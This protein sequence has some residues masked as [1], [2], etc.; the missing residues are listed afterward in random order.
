LSN[1]LAALWPDDPHDGVWWTGNNDKTPAVA[2]GEGTPP[3]IAKVVL[4]DLVDFEQAVDLERVL[5][6]GSEVYGRTGD[7][8]AAPLYRRP[9]GVIEEL[10]PGYLDMLSDNPNRRITAV[11]GS[12]RNQPVTVWRPL[13]VKQ[14]ASMAKR[15]ILCGILMPIRFGAR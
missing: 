15:W 13:L 3:S 6:N 12:K 7:G 14:R 10:D 11:K 9:S 1:G 5:L 8:V 4:E 2:E